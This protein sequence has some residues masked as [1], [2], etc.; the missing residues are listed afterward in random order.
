MNCPKCQNTMREREKGHVIIDVCPACRGVWL[1]SGELDNLIAQEQRYYD[2][3]DDDDDD[4]DDDE[5]RGYDDR[6]LERDQRGGDRYGRTGQPGRRRG[7]F[8]SNLFESIG[9]EG[10]D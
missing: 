6:R 9:G 8:L 4:D 3:D 2:R 1:D 5:R 7:G 10:N